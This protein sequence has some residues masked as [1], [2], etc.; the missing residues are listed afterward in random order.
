VIGFK[1]IKVLQR[2]CIRV[3]KEMSAFSKEDKLAMDVKVN[4]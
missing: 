2:R 3:E 4:I 1:S